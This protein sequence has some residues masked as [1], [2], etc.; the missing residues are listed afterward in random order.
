MSLNNRGGYGSAGFSGSE[1][2]LHGAGSY[3][4]SSNAYGYSSAI[5]DSY[6]NIY[7]HAHY[8]YHGAVADY[9]LSATND[10]YSSH[11]AATE[12]VSFSDPNYAP[13]SAY[14]GYE[15]ASYSSVSI[16]SSPYYQNTVGAIANSYSSGYTVGYAVAGHVSLDSGSPVYGTGYLATV[17]QASGPG[18]YVSY[19]TTSTY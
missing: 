15:Y 17:H 16:D 12:S 8:S 19:T 2:G 7:V 18:G 10:G 6:G 5:E 3:Y 11:I 13:T 14:G 9:N 4:T 1:A